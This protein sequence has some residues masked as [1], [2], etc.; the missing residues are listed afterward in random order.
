MV[1]SEKLKQAIQFVGRLSLALRP[2]FLQIENVSCAVVGAVQSGGSASAS[3]LKSLLE[4]T[5][6]G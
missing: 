5:S 6:T 3:A 1:T 4:P 2:E